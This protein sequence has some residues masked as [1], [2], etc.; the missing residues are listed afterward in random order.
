MKLITLAQARDHVKA[1]GDDDELLTAYCNAAE[2]HCARLANRSL[3]ATTTE[4]NAA[5][6]TVGTRMAAAYT[7]YDAAILAA[8]AHDD[9]RV[10]AMLAAAA[11]T[12][13]TDATTACERD[14]HG[15]ALDAAADAAGLPANDAVKAAILLLVGHY[16]ATRPA[17]ITGQGASAIEVPQGTTDIMANYRWIGPEYV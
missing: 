11:N 17:V 4:K 5:V 10:G 16:Y 14:V 2:A 8:E 15:L 7:A 13:L 1:D 12:A 9:C 3:F 6:A